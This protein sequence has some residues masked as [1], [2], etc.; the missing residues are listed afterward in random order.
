MSKGYINSL[1]SSIVAPLLFTKKPDGGLKVCILYQ[2]INCKSV[3][4]QYRLFLIEDILN[5]V[6][7][8]GIYLKH[9]F[10]RVY[11]L[12]QVMEGDEHYLAFQMRYGLFQLTV[13]QFQTT[14]AAADFQGY[15]NN[16]IQK[17][18]D[19]IAC[20]SFND[21][22]LYGKIEEDYVE[23]V[24]WVMQRLLKAELYLKPEK[25]EFH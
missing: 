9:D 2:D 6:V 24:Q 14:N 11:S 16:A 3:R 13:K 17:T 1:L 10:W 25:S 20:S 21:V 18:L 22:L 8:P 4:N 19:N 5:L 12:L 15:I 23:H 7:R